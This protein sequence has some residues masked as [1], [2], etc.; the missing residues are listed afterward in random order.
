MEQAF[1]KTLT[2][3]DLEI[4]E[5][6]QDLIEQNHLN[7]CVECGK[8]S[9]VCPMVPFYGEDFVYKR[10]SRAIAERLCIDPTGVY[11]ES[12]WYCLACQECTFFCPSGVTFQDFIMGLRNLLVSKGHTQYAHFCSE[13]GG[14]MMPKRQFSA[15]RRN[16]NPRGDLLYECPHCKRNKQAEILRRISPKGNCFR[17]RSSREP[18]PSLMPGIG[19]GAKF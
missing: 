16:L 17:A 2:G 8:C 12:I 1:G 5:H 3:K 18:K 14:Y 13:C 7:M 4:R 11:G 6:I 19:T 15:L 10:S 9:A